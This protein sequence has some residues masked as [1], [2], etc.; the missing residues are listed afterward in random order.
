L[1]ER[2]NIPNSLSLLRVFMVAPFLVAVIYR[3]FPLA[4]AIFVV[5]GITDFL[6]G[7]LA[8]HLRQKTVLGTFL[9]PLGDRLLSTVAFISLSVQGLLP[10]WLAVTVVAKDL[11]VALGAGALH[12]SGNLAVAVPSF[13]GKLSTLL[14]IIAVGSALL[15]A[16]TAINAALLNT[17]FIVTG[18]VTA[19]TCFHYI[20]SG[21]KVLSENN[22]QDGE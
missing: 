12:F 20:W 11:Y 22:K 14:Q 9:D 5:A 6:D 3:Q 8:R 17:L 16:F 7:Y 13:W 4:L 18:L 1:E 21:V 19:I 10:P 15:A 2:V